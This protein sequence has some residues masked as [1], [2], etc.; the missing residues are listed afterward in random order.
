MR[1]RSLIKRARSQNATDVI[2]HIHSGRHRCFVRLAITI[3]SALKIWLSFSNSRC[4]D[5]SKIRSCSMRKSSWPRNQDAACRHMRWIYSLLNAKICSANFR[6]L[7][8]LTR[9]V[10]SP[11][12]PSL[13]IKSLTKRLLG[14][15]VETPIVWEPCCCWHCKSWF[16]KGRS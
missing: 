10:N 8:I 14:L 9:P 13:R 4:L 12:W 5:S 2:Q 11:K 15:L 16:A 3:T 7:S 6:R 1:L